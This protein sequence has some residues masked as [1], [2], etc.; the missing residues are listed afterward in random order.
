MRFYVVLIISILF[1]ISGFSNDNSKKRRVEKDEETEDS[2]ASPEK[3]EKSL[4]TKTLQGKVQSKF[5]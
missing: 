2:D 5:K 3:T 1:L 4:I